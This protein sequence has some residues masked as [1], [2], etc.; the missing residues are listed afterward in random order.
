MKK[1]IK[2]VICLLTLLTTINIFCF[3]GSALAFLPN[4]EDL[5][6]AIYRS[7]AFGY[8]HA[9][10]YNGG[11]WVGDDYYYTAYEM[12]GGDD[13][14][15]LNLMDVFIGSETYYGSYGHPNVDTSA[16]EDNILDTCSD[17][18]NDDTIA[19]TWDDMIIPESGFGSY[20]S[21]SEIANIR[22]DGVVEYA[23]E[24]NNFWVWG[25]ANPCNSSG[26]PEHHDVSYVDYYSEHNNLGKD[27]PWGE[28]SP[29]VQRGAAGTKWTTLR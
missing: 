14:V 26:T 18:E 7:G 13:S 12:P 22:C 17:L 20:I 2:K 15:E 6:D 11:V 10:V 27:Q 24:W 9:G 29:Y 23:Y 3:S 5:A 16:E 1:Y 8:N 28:A 4:G 21:P 25:R 19:Y